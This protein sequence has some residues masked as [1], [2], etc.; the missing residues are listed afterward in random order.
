MPLTLEQRLVVLKDA[1]EHQYDHDGNA[2]LKIDSD[3]SVLQAAVQVIN[4]WG[5]YHEISL[6]SNEDFLMLI[7]M[8]IKFGRQDQ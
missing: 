7:D 8:V 3:D 4:F 5:G 2:K 1:M 6:S